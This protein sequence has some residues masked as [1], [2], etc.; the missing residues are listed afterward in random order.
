MG[1]NKVKKSDTSR[2]GV[3]RRNK[4]CLK[5]NDHR[6]FSDNMSLWPCIVYGNIFAYF[7]TF[8]TT[9]ATVVYNY[10]ELGFVRTV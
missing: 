8:H 10:F 7:S 1:R 4:R 3:C 5:D 2:T 6:R 9:T